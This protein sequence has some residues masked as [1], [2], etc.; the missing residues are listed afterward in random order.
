[1]KAEAGMAIMDI[2]IASAVGLLVLVAVFQLAPVLG[3]SIDE[4]ADLGSGEDI[5]AVAATGK[6]VPS[7]VVIEIVDGDLVVV[8][9]VPF[10]FDVA[11]DGCDPAYVCIT[12]VEPGSAATLQQLAEAIEANA[13]TAAIVDAACEIDP[14]YNLT[15]MNLVADAQGVDGND[16]ATKTHTT[17]KCIS[18]DDIT[19]TGG[20]D[21]VSGNVWAHEDV[22]TGVDAWKENASLLMLVVLVSLLGLAIM[23]IR[24]LQ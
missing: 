23:I 18:F 10:E 12:E 4:V 13:T 21:G 9:E 14:M 16:I 5:D 22:P 3:N 15:V 24:G 7:G 17:Y 19:L 2:V 11:M 8:G 20:V 1:M 6:L